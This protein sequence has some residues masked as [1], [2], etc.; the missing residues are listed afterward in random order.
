VKFERTLEI[1]SVPWSVGSAIRCSLVTFVDEK[2]S[3]IHVLIEGRLFNCQAAAASVWLSSRRQIPK[4]SL[5]VE[6][7]NPHFSLL[8][9]IN[10]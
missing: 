2:T 6:N 7:A 4:T 3:S 1:G 8:R 10:N 5:V 9:L